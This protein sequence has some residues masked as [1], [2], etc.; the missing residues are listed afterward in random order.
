M[1][2]AK[3]SRL[4][5]TVKFVPGN[6]NIGAIVYEFID[7]IAAHDKIAEE[8]EL[9]LTRLDKCK[10]DFRIKD[11]KLKA[12]EKQYKD[13][14]KNQDEYLEYQDLVKRKAPQY[15][16]RVKKISDPADKLKAERQ[17]KRYL[18]KSIVNGQ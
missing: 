8:I 4:D 7:A 14:N 6:D 2:T 17:Y 18:G 11:K 13:I 12:I 10:R 1:N 9:C 3:F 16:E 15:L 5:L